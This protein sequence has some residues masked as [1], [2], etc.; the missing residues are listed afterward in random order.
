MGQSC[1]QWYCS[2]NLYFS[3]CL[4]YLQYYNPELSSWL[5]TES[6]KNEIFIHCVVFLFCLLLERFLDTSSWWCHRGQCFLAS[7][8]SPFSVH[9][10]EQ[11]LLF[12][13]QSGSVWSCRQNWVGLP[14]LYLLTK[15]FWWTPVLPHP[16]HLS[17][18]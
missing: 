7:S 16:P 15:Y 1:F 8:Y 6:L 2:F 11:E 3:I 18:M 14:S 13:F 5:W 17:H 9:P 12:H 4:I 10:Q